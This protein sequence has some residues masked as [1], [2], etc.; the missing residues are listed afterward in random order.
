MVPI[1]VMIEK[2]KLLDTTHRVPAA[3]GQV[4]LR[5]GCVYQPPAR[6]GRYT[7]NIKCGL[8]SVRLNAEAEKARYIAS[9]LLL[10][11]V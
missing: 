4:L 10:C 9:A 11:K 6:C 8:R 1:K 2:L 3:Y 5:E 7:G